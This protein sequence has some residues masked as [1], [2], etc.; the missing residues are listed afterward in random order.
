[1]LTLREECKLRDFENRMLRSIFRPKRDD[2]TGEWRR[3]H[4]KELYDAPI[5]SPNVIWVIVNKTL[6]GRACSTYRERRNA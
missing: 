6:M 2:V 1:L 5:F 3:L 4:N